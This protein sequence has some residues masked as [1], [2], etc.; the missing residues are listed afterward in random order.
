M[1]DPD[2]TVFQR[3]IAERKARREEELR[4]QQQA[5]ELAGDY[6]DLI[7]EPEFIKSEADVE[8]DRVISGIDIIAAYNKWCGKSTPKVGA[9]QTENIMISCPT[10]HHADKNPSAWISTEK[11][12][13]YCGACEIGGDAHDIAAY[14]F[15][16]PVPQYK[17]GAQFHNLRKEMAADFGYV[18]TSLPGG[19]VQVTHSEEVVAEGEESPEGEQVAEVIEMYDGGDQ[20]DLFVPELKWREIIPTDTFMDVY[21]KVTTRDDVPEEYHF[22]NGL[23]ALG[24][25]LGRD[26][27]LD[28]LVPVYPNLF[29]CTLGRSGSGKSKARYHLDQLM[30]MALPHDWSDPNSKGVRKISSPGSAEVLIHNFQKPVPDPI[31]PK[32][33]AY[34]APVRGLIDFSELSS[35]IAR[36]NRMGNATTPT[37][38]QFYDMENV[39]ATSSMTHGAKEAHQPFASAI[40]TTQPK[41]LK[42]LLTQQDVASGFLNRWIFV[43]GREKQ[44]FAIGGIRIDMAPAVDPLKAIQGWASTFRPDQF[45]GWSPEAAERFTQFFHERIEPDK[46]KSASE[47]ITRIDLLVKKLILLFTANQLLDVVPLSAVESAINCYDYIIA[48][49]MIPEEQIGMTVSGEISEAIQYQA[50]KQFERNGRGVTLNQLAKSLK[51]R[52]YTNKQLLQTVEELVKLGFLQIEASPKGQ[53]GRPTVRYRHVG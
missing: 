14:H 5:A 42:G 24:F 6:S 38:M 33:V 32:K 46:A 53:V 30:S 52:N 51:R 40:T 28:D 17:S 4:K 31:D 7:P 20:E 50:R 45:M 12:T 21:M 36:T 2:L 35:L 41:S 26:V 19:I 22:F 9:S 18:F 48:S 27:R 3:K 13:W 29:I 8:M 15:G 49:Y 43:P 10:P 47:L 1:A 11:Q 44:R 23:L 16:Y 25:A 37:M 39:I 34:Y